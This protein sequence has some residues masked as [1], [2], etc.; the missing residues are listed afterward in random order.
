MKLLN[1]R[2]AANESG[3]AYKVIRHMAKAGHIRI[4]NLPGRN[5]PLVDLDDVTAAVERC[6]TNV[7]GGAE[8]GAIPESAPILDVAKSTTSEQHRR[9]NPTRLKVEKGLWIERYRK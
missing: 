5:R 2:Q 4:V 9:P 6:K 3:I 1:F 7:V 8:S